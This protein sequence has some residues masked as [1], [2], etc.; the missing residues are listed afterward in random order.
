MGASERAF[1]K[2]LHDI[3]SVLR[4]TV[5]SSVKSFPLLPVRLST[6]GMKQQSIAFPK[7]RQSP[8]ACMSYRAAAVNQDFTVNRWR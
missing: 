5:L 4:V 2:E 7:T 8:N 6:M 3:Y 1:S